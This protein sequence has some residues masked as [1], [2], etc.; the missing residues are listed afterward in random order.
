MRQA[1]E[2]NSP[3]KR[4]KASASYQEFKFSRGACPRRPPPPPFDRVNS[5]TP[6]LEDAFDAGLAHRMGEAQDECHAFL[7]LLFRI[8]RSG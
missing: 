1:H 3:A 4:P 5:D 2:R 6:L 7:S 8:Q